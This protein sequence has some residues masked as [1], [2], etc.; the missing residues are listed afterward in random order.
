MTLERCSKKIQN[1]QTVLLIL[2]AGVIR[3]VLKIF[4]KIFTYESSICQNLTLKKYFLLYYK[5]LFQLKEKEIV[6]Q[7]FLTANLRYEFNQNLSRIEAFIQ[8]NQ[9]SRKKASGP[10]VNPRPNP[11]LITRLKNFLSE[12]NAEP[13]PLY[14]KEKEKNSEAP[15]KTKPVKIV[16]PDSTTQCSPPVFFNNASRSSNS[17]SEPSTR[18][19]FSLHDVIFGTCCVFSL[20]LF[21][22]KFKK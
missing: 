14:F 3:Y 9:A 22:T 16:L 17:Y 21:L 4:V 20:E 11:K 13:P 7:L 18:L 10:F 1:V 8:K 6:F 19:V 5:T 15:K 2:T 12:H